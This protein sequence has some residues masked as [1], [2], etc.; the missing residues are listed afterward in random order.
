MTALACTRRWEAEAVEDGRLD[1]RASASFERHVA[2][3]P[4]CAREVV[5]LRQVRELARRLDAPKLAPLEQRR[6]RARLL[7]TAHQA[8][9]ELGP[10]T[11]RW[12]GVLAAGLVAAAATL[13]WLAVRPHAGALAHA[14]AATPHYEVQ[15][16]ADTV[17][18]NQSAGSFACLALARGTLSVHVEHLQRGQRFVVKL[19]DGQLEVRGTRFVVNAEHGVTERVTVTEG[20]VELTLAGSTTRRLTAGQDWSRAERAYSPDA[21]PSVSATAPNT[22]LAPFSPP[23]A[24]AKHRHDMTARPVAAPPRVEMQAADS[25]DAHSAGNTTLVPA[26]SFAG[27]MRAFSTGAYL[28]ADD[29]FAEFAAHFPSDSR[30]EDALFLRAVV[31]VRRGDQAAALRRAHEY[32]RRFP[33]GL[34][35]NEMAH[36]V[37]ASELAD[38]TQSSP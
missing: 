11:S 5:S 7:Q 16:A 19:P 2:A 10:E 29:R 33:G 30:C 3:C 12:R 6:S 15:S 18:E 27:A 22:R 35:K 20:V 26:D 34:R 32:L 13:L 4:E 8:L 31:A 1:G 9:L 38:A 28:E 25:P 23:V 36:L 17:F 21:K 24:R 37:G 14:H